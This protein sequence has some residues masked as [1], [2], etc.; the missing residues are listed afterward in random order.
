MDNILIE[1]EKLKNMILE[2]EEYKKFIKSRQI[3][4][5]NQEINDIIEKIKENQKSI[6]KKENENKDTTKEEINLRSLYSEL[7]KFDEYKIYLENSKV[8]NILITSIQKKF[9][10]Y[11]N[12]FVI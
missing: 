12:K 8:L 9:E 10:D 6:I 3:L 1:V 7:D 11:F 2:T 5:N 4:D